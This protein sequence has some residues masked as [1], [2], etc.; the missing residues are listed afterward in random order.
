MREI[1]LLAQPVHPSARLLHTLRWIAQRDG[2]PVEVWDEEAAFEAAYTAPETL[3]GVLLHIPHGLF[4][5]GSQLREHLRLAGVRWNY[6]PPGP[7]GG[8]MAAGALSAWLASGTPEPWQPHVRDPRW[9][10]IPTMPAS[11]V[12]KWH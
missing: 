8:L 2:L 11:E 4:P 12:P 10:R 9:C 5:E 1:L 7:P 3:G 6:L